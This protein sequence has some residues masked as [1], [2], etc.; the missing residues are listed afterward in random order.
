MLLEITLFIRGISCFAR[1]SGIKSSRL[2]DVAYMCLCDPFFLCMYHHTDFR[3]TNSSHDPSKLQ[4]CC[5]S[6]WYLI[7]VAKTPIC[8][9]LFW[10]SIIL[11]SGHFFVDLTSVCHFQTFQLAVLISSI[12]F[13]TCSGDNRSSKDAAEERSSGQNSGGTVPRL[14][15]RFD[16]GKRLCL[17][18]VRRREAAVL[19]LEA[20]RARS[21]Q[22]PRTAIACQ[23]NYE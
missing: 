11:V 4:N 7:L 19:S 22:A 21:A 13:L 16:A 23:T 3:P 10:Q 6:C 1:P 9:C 14:R 20:R 2:F 17:V 18:V 8:T 5:L 15:S 12:N